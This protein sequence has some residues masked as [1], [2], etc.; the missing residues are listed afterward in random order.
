MTHQVIFCAASVLSTMPLTYS[1]RRDDSDFVWCSAS[2]SR[3]T[4]RP[5]PGASTGNACQARGRQAG[6][7]S[8]LLK[9]GHRERC[10]R[11]RGLTADLT[12]VQF[13][14]EIKLLM[15]FA[16]PI[17]C[18]EGVFPFEP[19]GQLCISSLGSMGT[20][21]MNLPLKL[22]KA[23]LVE[24]I[25]ELRFGALFPASSILPG[26]LFSHLN[27]RSVDKLPMSNF[28]EQVRSADP[29]LMYA[30][31]VK[32]GWDAF[33]ILISDRS[34]ALGCIV[35][36]PGWRAFKQG[37]LKVVD[38]AGTAN[39]VQSIERFSLKYIN[40][41]P[42]ELGEI[43]SIA[44]LD[45]RI[46]PYSA[47]GHNVQLRV[48]IRHGELIRVL[49][50][51]SSAMSTFADGTSRSGPLLDIDV[52]AVIEKNLFSEFSNNLPERVELVHAEAKAA[53]FT[54]VKPEIIKQLEPIYA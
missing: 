25:F 12:G 30:P 50:I 4:R 49:T 24:A 26:M 9:R 46:G 31:L 38:I 10:Y 6:R 28:P 42:A 14:N 5:L 18:D 29:N 35:P 52:I 54:C 48:E 47:E 39:V 37:I 45:V 32:I 11:K 15:L 7:G 36:Y 2:P 17:C 21:Q 22:G 27:G 16:A 43:G 23:P 1:L 3:S 33:T 41:F 13:T 51:A 53:F 19:R 44:N 8:P 40:I 34:V 20:N